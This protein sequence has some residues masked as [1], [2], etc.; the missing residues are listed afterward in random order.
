MLVSREEAWPGGN[1]VVRPKYLL[2]MHPSTLE[3]VGRNLIFVEKVNS[4]SD[5]VPEAFP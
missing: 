2:L 5:A 4:L 3:R 1:A